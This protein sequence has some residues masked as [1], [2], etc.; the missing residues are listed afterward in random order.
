MQELQETII[1]IYQKNLLFLKK[2]FFYIYK[3]IEDLEKNLVET[4]HIDYIDNHFELVYQDK[5]VYNCDPFFDA[6]YRAKNIY[7]NDNL[8][9]LIEPSKT[10]ITY[11]GIDE[12]IEAS[13]FI[14]EYINEF[15]NINISKDKS[16]KFIF[17][18]TLLGVHL[19]D[20]HRVLK[21]KVYLII[22]PNIEI[23][24]LSLFLTDYEEIGNESQLFFSISEND[25]TL[26]NN[27][28]NFLKY[29]S[30]YNSFIRFELA[31]HNEINLVS[32]VSEIITLENK[33]R[34]PFSEYIY[35]LKRGI[36]YLNNNPNGII[37]TTVKKDFLKDAPV[38]FL[39]AGP[40]LDKNI[41]FIKNCQD[42]FTIVAAAATLK[43]LEKQQIQPDIIISIDAGKETVKNQFD[44]KKEFFKNSIIITSIKTD[45][46][47]YEYINNDKV[48]F[49]Q[50]SIEFLIN[51]GLLLGVTVGD[52]GL[53][54]LLTLGAKEIYLL[55]L[56]AAIDE[57]TNKTHFSSYHYNEQIEK[58]ELNSYKN[59]LLDVKGNFCNTVKTTLLYKDMI[60]SI[61]EI[62]PKLLENS[63]IY[64]LSKGA[65]FDNTIALKLLDIN[66]SNFKKFDKY[67][68]RNSI[69][70][71]LKTITRNNLEKI[72]INEI[73]KEKKIIKRLKDSKNIKKDFEKLKSNF[74]T[75][76]TIQILDEFFM[77]T[78]PYEHILNNKDLQIK[79][80]IKIIEELE[81]I[82]SK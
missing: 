76:F 78:N 14:N 5:K 47:I 11:G 13:K 67:N 9:S 6:Q 30:I 38:L 73:K 59:Y 50:T 19:N 44:V 21:S 15:K 62:S 52:I 10:L 17:L 79:Q 57:K 45:P 46:K 77:L 25:E 53:K 82:Y 3:K 48:F 81:E 43:F 70:N 51:A 32:K 68:F 12:K 22:E 36:F 28:I 26:K 60:D 1:Q 33:I 4:Y 74:P 58:K 27:I 8:F 16:D 65:Y 34:Y 55:G 66:I 40:S 75:S 56:D 23:F 37:N 63:T 24:R 2:N 31:S 41:D 61:N 69:F 39:A 49:V 42:R 54:I 35:S 71:Q 29:K 80:F 18:G 7:N 64:N 72:D 20:I